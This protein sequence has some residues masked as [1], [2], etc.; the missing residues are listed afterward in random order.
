MLLFAAAQVINLKVSITFFFLRARSFQGRVFRTLG[1]STS[2]SLM[3]NFLSSFSSFS[4]VQRRQFSGLAR[5]SGMRLLCFYFV[6]PPPPASS[7]PCLNKRPIIPYLLFFLCDVF[8]G[9][10]WATMGWVEQEWANFSE[11]RRISSRFTVEISSLRGFC[12]IQL[13]V[14]R[15]G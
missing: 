9:I 11:R 1:S 4:F 13:R 10:F 5:E 7:S 8:F 2:F 14:R 15:G 3:I 6:S 12:H